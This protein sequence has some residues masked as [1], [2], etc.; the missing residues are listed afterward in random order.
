MK[1]MWEIPTMNAT[2]IDDRRRLVMPPEFKPKSAVTVQ[3][4][5]SETA[6]VKLAKPSAVRMVMLLPDVK[7]LPRD[8]EWE[9]VEHRMVKHAAKKVTQFE[10]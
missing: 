8:P 10:E 7:Q 3:M 6:V 9:A 4:I 2:V 5:D 1:I